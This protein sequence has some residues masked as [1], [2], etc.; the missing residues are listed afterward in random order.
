MTFKKSYVPGI[1]GSVLTLTVI[2]AAP[3]KAETKEETILNKTDWST[4]A[5]ANVEG[6]ANIRSEASVDSEIVGVLMPGYAVAVTEKGNEWSKI[7]SNGVE[8]YIK[9][10]YLVFGEEAKA[11]YRNMCGIIGVVQADSLRV[12]EAASTDSAQVGTLTQNGEVSVFGEEA[13]WYQIQYSGSS[14]YVHGDYVTLSEELKGAVSMEEYQASQACVASSAAAASTAGSASVISA[15]S[16]DVAML[17]ALIECEAGGES[18]TGMVAVG[19]VVVN[20]VNSG[21]FPNSVS[22]VI[23]QGGQF[24]PV[25]TGTFQSVTEAVDYTGKTDPEHQG[26]YSNSWYSYAWMTA[27][28]LNAQI[29]DIAQGGIALMDGQGW[30]HEPDQIGMESAWNKIRFNKTFGE[31]TEWDFN[32]YTPQV[33][34]VAIGQNDNHPFDYMSEDYMC[35]KAILWR[36]HYT[37]FL[38]KLRQVYPKASVVCCT[39]LLEHDSSWDKAIDDVVVSMGDSKIS[40]CIFKRNGAATPGH[41]RIPETYEMARELADYIENLG[42]EEWK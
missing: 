16:N 2:M 12:R 9:N 27:R 13:D 20:R 40:H 18:Y 3:V 34:V 33:V 6:Y 23:Y 17:A 7:S 26:G 24:T 11:H 25:A 19:A 36:E 42:I 21:S 31:L 35:E 32:Q 38:K 37:E 41:L 30:F 15:D 39:T 22:G 8:G 4:M 5:A 14:A 10:E 29:H 1:L 28:M